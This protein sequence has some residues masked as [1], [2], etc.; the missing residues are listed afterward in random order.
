MSSFLSSVPTCHAVI[1]AG[2]P[3]RQE[4][5]DVVATRSAIQSRKDQDELKQK[6]VRV[7][8]TAIPKL[9]F[10]GTTDTMVPINLVQKLC[11]IGGNGQLRIHDKG[12]LFPTKAKYRKEM[13]EF[14]KEHL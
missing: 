12:H 13:I 11:E 4:P 2:S 1:T 5:F 8:G 3:Y 7:D 14:L 10:A 6:E 9:H